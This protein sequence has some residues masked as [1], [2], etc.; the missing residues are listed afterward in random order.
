MNTHLALLQRPMCRQLNLYIF[1]SKFCQHYAV[2]HYQ[3]IIIQFIYWRKGK[4]QPWCRIKLLTVKCISV[5]LWT[6]LFQSLHWNPVYWIKGNGEKT[7]LN[8][9]YLLV[10]FSDYP[11]ENNL[12]NKHVLSHCCA[13]VLSSDFWPLYMDWTPNAVPEQPSLLGCNSIGLYFSVPGNR[14]C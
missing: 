7:D 10:T 3:S 8:F 13:Y 6:I 9:V 5:V 11:E 2:L 4:N 14:V 1:I 12:V